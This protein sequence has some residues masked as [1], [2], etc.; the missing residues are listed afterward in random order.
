[1]VLLLLCLVYTGLSLVYTGLCLLHIRI[2]EK[3]PFAKILLINALERSYGYFPAK[4]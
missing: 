2:P 1:M 3:A 4:I